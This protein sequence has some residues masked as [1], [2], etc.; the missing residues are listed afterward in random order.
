MRVA[1]RELTGTETWSSTERSVSP[2]VAMHNPSPDEFQ[3]QVERVLEFI[4]YP[5]RFD[6]GVHRASKGTMSVGGLK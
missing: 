2:E 4:V 6:R 1:K 5:R 3:E